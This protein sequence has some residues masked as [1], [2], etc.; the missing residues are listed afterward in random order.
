MLFLA[1]KTNRGQGVPEPKVKFISLYLSGLDM[2]FA[3]QIEKVQ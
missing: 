3:S 2:K 1:I